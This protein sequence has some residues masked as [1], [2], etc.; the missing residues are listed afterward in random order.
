MT[1]TGP[2][3]VDFDDLTLAPFGYDLAKLVVSTAMT[4]GPLPAE[5]ITAALVRLH[6]RA[7]RQYRH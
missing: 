2:A 6:H 5:A 3:I 7:A 1:A 4:H